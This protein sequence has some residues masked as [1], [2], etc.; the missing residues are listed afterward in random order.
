MEIIC[1]ITKY[2]GLYYSLKGE[3]YG[4]YL[5]V[6]HNDTIF[7]ASP[8]DVRNPHHWWQLE[9]K[10]KA[11]IMEHKNPEIKRAFNLSK[12]DENYFEL[13]YG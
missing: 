3:Q 9:D 6:N 5:I 8:I 4:H 7:G 13:I 2:K 12:Y 1:H 11:V 10:M